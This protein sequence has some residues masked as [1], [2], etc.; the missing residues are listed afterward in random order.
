MKK[1][2]TIQSCPPQ[3]LK[4]NFKL[5][6]DAGYDGIELNLIDT[7]EFTM[8]TT[9]EQI[10]EIKEHAKNN[11]IE[12]SSVATNQHWKYFLTSEDERNREMAKAVI[13]NQIDFASWL[14]CDT[15]LVVPGAVGVDFIKECEITDYDVAYKRAFDGIKEVSA[16]AEEKKVCIALENVGNKLLL[17]PLETRDFID[18]IGSDY[19]GAFFDI[20][21]V[22]KIGYPD[23]WIRI[24]GKRIKRTH[25]K[26]YKRAYS[27]FVN[28]MEG[29]VDFPSAMEALKEIGYDGW[30][31]AE[32]TP[33]YKYYPDMLVRT[34]S[35]AMDRIMEGYR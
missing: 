21:N 29:D 18:K 10:E 13:R 26:D 23:Q 7:G 12:I 14:G 9:R 16:Y 24:L 34:T 15:I 35:L 6:H 4:E 20:G 3:S 11:N 30:I 27:G 8:Q 2:I 31:S 25:I 32:I 5:V 22:L 17:S 28:L 19:V 1:G 33:L